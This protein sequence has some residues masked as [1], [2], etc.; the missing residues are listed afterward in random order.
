MRIVDPNAA[1]GAG[2]KISTVLPGTLLILT[3]AALFGSAAS[4]AEHNKRVADP[5]KM[6]CRTIGETGSRL[7]RSRAC[8]TAAE[9]E[10]L[11]RQA[12]GNVEKIQAQGRATSGG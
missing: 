4:A 6:I 7:N 3:A 2:M 10:D 5:N 1:G 8:H 9:W 11:R 12:T